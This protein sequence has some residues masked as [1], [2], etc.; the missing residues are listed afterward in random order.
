MA[1]LKVTSTLTSKDEH[2]QS[3]NVPVFKITDIPQVMENKGWKESAR[4]MRK[5]FSD[6]LF[7]MTKQQKLNKVDMSKID[8]K[9]ILDD[10]SFDW[11]LTSSSRVKPIYDNFVSSIS[12]IVEYDDF[13]GRKKKIL[14]QLSNGLC[15]IIHRLDK[16]GYLVNGTLIN[17]Y[18]DYSS[19]SAI[20]LD[21][22]SQFNFISIGNTLW[23]KATDKLD[24]VYGALGSFIIKVAFT[25]LQ[26]TKDSNGFIKL[27]INELGMYVRDTYEFMNDGDDQPL[28]YWGFKGVIKPGI[29]SELTRR[30]YIDEGGDRYFRVTNSSFVNYRKNQKANNKTGDFFVYSTVKRIPVN[31]IIH[32]NKTDMEEYLYWKGKN[33]ND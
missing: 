11:L 26:V 1:D 7:E 6:P 18:L 19:L 16:S 33:T 14:D 24:D 25:D 27:E 32:L 17:C 23:E 29:I 10:L 15:Y 8:K 22:V 28:G 31:I 13:L 9:H 4:F 3:V 5:W 21:K 12:N 20:E 2:K 30:A